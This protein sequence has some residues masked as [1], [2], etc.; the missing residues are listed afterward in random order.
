MINLNE[1]DIKTKILFG[2]GGFNN[3]GDVAQQIGAKKRSDRV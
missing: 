3:L 1:F 2:R